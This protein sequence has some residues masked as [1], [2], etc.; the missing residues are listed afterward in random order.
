MAV[1]S[2][3][4][5][6]LTAAVFLTSVSSREGCSQHSFA[7]RVVQ[8]I[9]Q[10]ESL[11]IWNDFSKLFTNGTAHAAA[12]WMPISFETLAERIHNRD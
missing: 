7:S 10:Q 4:C 6:V 8:S 5:N 12:S 1:S 11:Q 3:D 9:A 2:L